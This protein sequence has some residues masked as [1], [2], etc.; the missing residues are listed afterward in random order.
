MALGVPLMS[1]E[2]ARD[3]LGWTPRHSA[4]EAITELVQGMREAAEAPTPPLAAGTSGP[5]R[6]RELL[7]GMGKPQ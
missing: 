3:G 4:I 1:P 7:T 5:G 6:I 2:R